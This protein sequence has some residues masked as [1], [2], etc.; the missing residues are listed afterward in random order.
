MVTIPAD[1]QG[2]DLPFVHDL[3]SQA[4]NKS[5]AVCAEEDEAIWAHEPFQPSEPTLQSDVMPMTE[6]CP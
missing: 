5:F 1:V 2:S 4:A 6:Y 3:G